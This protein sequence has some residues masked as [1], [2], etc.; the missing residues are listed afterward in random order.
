MRKQFMALG[1]ALLFCL[2]LWGHPVWSAESSLLVTTVREND[3]EALENVLASGSNVN[4]TDSRGHTALDQALSTSEA[5]W[6][7]GM[8]NLLLKHGGRPG[9]G[10]ADMPLTLT[11]L[12]ER[13][14]DIHAS[15]DNLS[16]ALHEACSWQG[17]PATVRLLLSMGLSVNA[18]TEED[19]GNMTPL[20]HAVRHENHNAD[21]IRLLLQH[22]ADPELRDDQGNR[23]TDGL[24]A[25]RIAWLKQNGLDMLW[26]NAGRSG[27]A[28]APCG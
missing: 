27:V 20:M 14:A 15:D 28:S 6:T 26:G 25:E 2:S 7:P 12:A 18:Q 22:G 19:S 24:S 16:S 23:A 4:E 11:R 1:M 13:G 5:S 8:V 3:M 21:V 9:S 17:S 10:E